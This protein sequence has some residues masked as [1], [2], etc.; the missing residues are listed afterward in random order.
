MREWLKWKWTSE[1]KVNPLQNTGALSLEATARARNTRY[2]LLVFVQ[3]DTW[4]NQRSFR[5]LLI[6]ETTRALLG[7]PRNGLLINSRAK[8]LL[9]IKEIK[10]CEGIFAHQCFLALDKKG[11]FMGLWSGS[12]LRQLQNIVRE[13]VSTQQRPV[14]LKHCDNVLHLACH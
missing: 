10:C 14:D 13:N 1:R 12:D 4:L 8:E 6:L 3:I 11:T 2:T 9:N 7:T 5:E